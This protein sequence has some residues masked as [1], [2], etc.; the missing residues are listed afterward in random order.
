MSE[1]NGSPRLTAATAG[2]GEGGETEQLVRSRRS[3]SNAKSLPAHDGVDG[4]QEAESMEPQQPS[5]L[6]KPS[7]GMLDRSLQAQ[8]GRQL[9]A[10]FSDVAEEP[11]PERFIKLL[12]ALEAKERGR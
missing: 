5:D 1:K 3:R 6:R 11:V 12:E 2:A 4:E 9:R 8:L 7:R 10:I